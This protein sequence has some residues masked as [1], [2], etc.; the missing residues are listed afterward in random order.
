LADIFLSYAG[1]NRDLARWIVK[2]L[3]DCGWS[4]FWD[5]ALNCG[6]PF[7]V[8]IE[9]ELDQ[10]GCVV[11]LWSNDSVNRHWPRSEAGRALRQNKL[12][13]VLLEEAQLPLEFER[14]EYVDAVGRD[15]DTWLRLLHREVS[16]HLGLSSS[17]VTGQGL[18]NGLSYQELISASLP[19]LQS[20]IKRL[21]LLATG[22][23]NRSVAH[24]KLGLCHI[25]LENY[26]IALTHINESL[27]E[28]PESA[29]SHYFKACTLL[30]GRKPRQLSLTEI[31]A[32]EAELVKACH[33]KDTPRQAYQLAALIKYDYYQRNG[34]LAE[35]STDSLLAQGLSAQ[36][37]S[38]E[39]QRLVA[40]LGAD[41]DE[42]FNHILTG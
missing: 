23:I 24:H 9:N 26:D 1:Q 20:I 31:R 30:R 2:W 28:N 10:A 4:V 12:V 19:Q 33:L 34:M 3:E 17:E 18:E 32:V 35:P 7:D 15:S 14:I 36:S 21:T 38:G 22:G 11:V 37:L 27:K 8:R 42:I 29:I 39:S 25:L 41:T 5:D 16:K 6:Q 13:Q 40:E